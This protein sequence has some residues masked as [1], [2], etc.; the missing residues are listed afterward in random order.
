MSGLGRS[1][2]SVAPNDDL[3]CC[4]A[5]NVRFEPI[6]T[7]A[8]R[9]MNVGFQNFPLYWGRSTFFTRVAQNRNF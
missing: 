1:R 8:V 7:E 9:N 2:Q 3:A 6:L 5:E 4:V